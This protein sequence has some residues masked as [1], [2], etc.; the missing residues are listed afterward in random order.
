M[1][2]VKENCEFRQNGSFYKYKK[3]TQNKKKV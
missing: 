1:N 2:I 3:M